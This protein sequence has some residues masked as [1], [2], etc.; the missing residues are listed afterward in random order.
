M[1][2]PYGWSGSDLSSTT[3]AGAATVLAVL[4]ALFL[5]VSAAGAGPC[6]AQIAEL[7]QQ[8][9]VATAGP[10]TG[11]T[12]PQSV[13]AQLHHQPTPGSV[14]HAEIRA[15]A[16]ADAALDRAR[17]ADAEG[18]ADACAQALREARHLYGI[19]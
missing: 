8:I 7:D 17:K 4:A 19:D 10:A 3:R 12:A 5:L 18:N 14:E 16:D 2:V 15:N 13:G 9:A 11:P 1:R 6:T